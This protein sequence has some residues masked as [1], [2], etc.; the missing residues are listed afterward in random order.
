MTPVVNR[1]NPISVRKNT[2]SRK[3]T[4]P[5]WKASKCVITLNA[6]ARFV[7]HACPS[8]STSR[9]TGGHPARIRNRQ[10][11]TDR[12]NDTTWF[13]VSDD[14]MHAIARYAPAI[15]PLPTYVSMWSVT[16][17]LLFS[18]AVG[19]FFGLY[20]AMRASR[21]DPVDSLRYE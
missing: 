13:R 9:V 1:A 19:V 11:T 20:P 7:S 4:T 21:L 17:G 14:V 8:E 6:A 3:S 10:M 2:R 12:I 15:S 5:R 18:A 16:T